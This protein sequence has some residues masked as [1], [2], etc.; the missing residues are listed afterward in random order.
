VC[1]TESPVNPVTNPNS[2]YNHSAIPV[3]IWNMPL[4][5]SREHLLW[6]CWTMDSLYAF[7]CKRFGHIVIFGIPLWS[8]FW[9]TLHYHWTVTIPGKTWSVSLHYGS[10]KH[11]TYSLDWFMKAFKAVKLFF[12]H[13]YTVE[14][15]I[16]YLLRSRKATLPISKLNKLRGL[17]PRANY[18]DRAPATCWG[19]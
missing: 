19:S 18:T 16:A 13:L 15:N 1:V 10:S 8:S 12:K 5:V 3:T 4:I 6:S 2:I 14:Y 11:C 7:K 17:S 9:S